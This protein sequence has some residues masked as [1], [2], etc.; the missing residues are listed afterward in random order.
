MTKTIYQQHEAAFANVSA[1]VLMRDGVRVGT[2]AFKYPNDGAGRLWCYLHIHGLPMVRD[3]AGGY[4]YDKASAAFYG[5]AKKQAMVKLE[6]WQTMD[7]TEDRALASL[8][9]KDWKN[10]YDWK[11]NLRNAGFAVLQAV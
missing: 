7:R 4:G 1:F 6:S 2:V 8:C 9:L 10:G 5:A 11:D 3:Y